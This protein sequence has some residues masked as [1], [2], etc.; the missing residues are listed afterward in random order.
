MPL[1]ALRLGCEAYANDLN[2]VAHIIELCT[3]LFP[4][5]YGQPDPADELFDQRW[6]G[7]ASGS[8]PLG[9]IGC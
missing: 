3:L 2:P 8:P 4:Q 6:Q 1:E 5:K 7:L 9:S